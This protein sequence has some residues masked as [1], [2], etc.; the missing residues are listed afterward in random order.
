MTIT[1]NDLERAHELCLELP[2]VNERLFRCG[3]LKT[4]QKM[5][6][7]VQAIGFET[8]EL[9]EKFERQTEKAK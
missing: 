5:N 4:A 8:A 6:L 2:L 1:R 9:D 3:L 7:A